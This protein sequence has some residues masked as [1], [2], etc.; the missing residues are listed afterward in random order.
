MYGVSSAAGHP[1]TMEPRTMLRLGGYSLKKP[2]LNNIIG[3]ARSAGFTPLSRMVD[4]IL[5]MNL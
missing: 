1:L 5:V 2:A 3:H 4:S